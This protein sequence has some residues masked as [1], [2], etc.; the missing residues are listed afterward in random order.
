MSKQQTILLVTTRPEQL[1]AFSAQLRADTS[2]LLR[3]SDSAE[4]ALA[5]VGR[6]APALVIV[7]HQVGD[8]PGLTL[9]RQLIQV[10]AFIHTAVLSEL[11]EAA[12][13]EASEGLGILAHL[14]MRPG[15][16]DARALLDVLRQVM[17]VA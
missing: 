6:Q 1:S 7:D 8:R 12:F 11:S 2:V 15:P 3:T 5:A 4:Q 14:P 10:N 9:V 13:H 17:P 16:D